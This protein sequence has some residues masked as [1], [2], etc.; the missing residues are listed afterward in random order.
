MLDG[1]T[2]SGKA[3][4]KS[5]C[6]QGAGKEPVVLQPGESIPVFSS[7]Q[8][9]LNA[10]HHTPW[11]MDCSNHN[12]IK[13]I[14]TQKSCFSFP[15]TSRWHYITRFE[16]SN[17]VHFCSWPGTTPLPGAPHRMALVC[18]LVQFISSLVFSK[19]LNWFYLCWVSS[20]SPQNCKGWCKERLQ[21]YFALD[22][23]DYS[24]SKI[25]L[26]YLKR[27]KS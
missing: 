9:Q 26:W 10:L 5:W 11:R 6:H 4:S 22:F 15:K 12:Q 13:T 24:Y 14:C 8:T 20:N 19:R 1:W 17:R 27:K 7:S 16:A 25:N 2:V 21:L 3:V 18:H 23:V